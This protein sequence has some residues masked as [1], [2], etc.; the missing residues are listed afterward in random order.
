MHYGAPAHLS[1]IVRR[2]L[3]AKFL[4]QR[5]GR[6]GPIA[7]SPCSPGLNPLDLY[8]YGHLKALVYS[9]PVDN[10]GTLGNQVVA[11]F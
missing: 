3:N 4:G 6:G 8:L 9:S 5:I 1:L 10:V 11:G 7:W 2:Y